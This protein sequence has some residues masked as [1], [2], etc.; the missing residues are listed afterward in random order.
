MIESQPRPEWSDLPRPGC[1]N[2]E[3]RV[4]LVKDDLAV[5]NLRFRRNATI[6]KHDA[7]FNIDVICIA[8]SG[9][10][11]I[12]EDTFGIKEGDTVRWPK[13]KQHCLWT[14]DT[15]METIMIERHGS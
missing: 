5:A 4:L 8:G 9:F 6:D 11:L 13:D 3:F 7:P 1:E 2:V 10:V 12:G 15:E 14:E